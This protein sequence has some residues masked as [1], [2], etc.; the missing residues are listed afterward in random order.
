MGC[1]LSV[2][3]VHVSNP[4][5]RPLQNHLGELGI[6]E[7]RRFGLFRPSES[8][9]D[10]S[11]VTPCSAHRASCL[12]QL[13]VVPPLCLFQNHRN[14]KTPESHPSRC[15]QQHREPAVS[16]S[17]RLEREEKEKREAVSA[18]ICV[19]QRVQSGSDWP[20]QTLHE[21]ME[22]IYS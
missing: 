22:V 2:F 1:S 13:T 10:V 19:F 17:C 21:S 4:P 5:P 14:V 6:G 3:H 16:V 8:G 11:G 12:Q 20:R 9:E 15:L 7:H 18:S